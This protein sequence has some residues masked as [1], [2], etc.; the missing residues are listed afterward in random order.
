[1]QHGIASAPVLFSRFSACS[2]H[3]LPKHGCRNPERFAEDQRLAYGKQPL[4]PIF[5]NIG[6][7]ISRD[8]S[9][10]IYMFSLAGSVP[11]SLTVLLKTGKSLTF[12]KYSIVAHNGILFSP[13][14]RSC[15]AHA[16]ACAQAI[17]NQIQRK[18]T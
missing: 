5:Q 11:E 18:V 16:C 13:L 10:L 8:L 12:C 1:M 3:L 14:M 6:Q 17:W 4:A 15:P 7:I 9:R 2:F